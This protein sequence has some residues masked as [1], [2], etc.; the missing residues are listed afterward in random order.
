M[1]TDETAIETTPPVNEYIKADKLPAKIAPSNV[2]TAITI[3]ASQGEYKI[4]AA[5]ENMFERPI[6]APG[7]IRGGKRLSIKNIIKLNAVKMA[8]VAIFFAARFDLL[9]QNNYTPHLK[10]SKMIFAV[11]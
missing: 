3:N 11:I 7:I 5:K 10:I 4:K 9:I 6:F 8:S 2:L 1:R